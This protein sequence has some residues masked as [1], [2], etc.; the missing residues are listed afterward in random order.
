MIINKNILITGTTSGIGLELENYF[1]KKNKVI[2]INRANSK[3]KKKNINFKTDITELEKVKNILIDLKKKNFLPDIVILNAGVNNYD[4]IDYF[5]IKN[6]KRC[7]DI[8]FYGAI[9]FVAAIDELK[10]KNIKIIFFSSTSTIIPN[11]SAL[12]YYSSKLLL[13]KLTKLFNVNISNNVF[14]CAILGPIKT[15]I[16]RNLLKPKGI[17]GYIYKLLLVDPVDMIKDFEK[18]ILKKKIFFHFTLVSVFTYY[19]ISIIITFF[20]NINKGPQNK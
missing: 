11:P 3:I 10:L 5:N 1:K 6:F 16:T 4:K 13:K 17:A 14:K 7:F 15:K 20:P 19:F 18:F 12:G 8:N 9:N 2:S